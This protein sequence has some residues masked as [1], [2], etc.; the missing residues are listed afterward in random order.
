MEET[1]QTHVASVNKKGFAHLRSEFTIR[2]PITL[3]TK[4][5]QNYHVLFFVYTPWDMQKVHSQITEAMVE[6]EPSRYSFLPICFA[7]VS[8]LNSH[9]EILGGSSKELH[10]PLH[11]Y[12]PKKYIYEQLDSEVE[13]LGGSL[14]SVTP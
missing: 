4:D 1:H 8:L 9:F 10:L 6:Q 14:L 5:L 2:V 3:K 7:K 13:A 12:T 11:K